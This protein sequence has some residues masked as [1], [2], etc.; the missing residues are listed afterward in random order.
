M[1]KRVKS[2]RDSKSFWRI[3]A[4]QRRRQSTFR[5]P[6]NRGPITTN[7][8][9]TLDCQVHYMGSGAV[10][11]EGASVWEVGDDTAR[12]LGEVPAPEGM[13]MADLTIDCAPREAALRGL[14]GRVS[15]NFGEIAVDAALSCGTWGSPK[16]ELSTEEATRPRVQGFLQC[17]R[18]GEPARERDPLR[19][20][21]SAG[22]YMT[23]LHSVIGS[24]GS[25]PDLDAASGVNFGRR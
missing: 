8:Q 18:S 25:G 2:L 7:T 13:V 15:G 22:D 21:G 16:V 23:R 19:Q 10:R 20:T 3:D 12:W 24:V 14:T 17:R 6:K 4:L 1:I 11:L 5:R 9:L